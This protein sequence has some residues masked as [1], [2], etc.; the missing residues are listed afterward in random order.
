MSEGELVSI[1]MPTYECGSFIGKSIKSVQA[2][3]YRNWELI[4]VDDCS[5]DC[6]AEIVTELSKDDDRITYYQNSSNSGAA[7]SRNKALGLAK[8]RWIAFLDSDDLWEPEKLERQIKF[9]KETGCAFSYHEYKEIDGRD[10]ESGVYVSGKE[11]VGKF[12]MYACCWPGCLS[13]MYDAERIGL[14][15]I[16]D[17]KKNNDTAM[18]LKVIK[19]ADCYLLKECL[20]KYRRRT[21]SITPRTVWRRICAHYPLFRRAEE[22]NP[23]AASFWVMMNVIGNAYKKFRYVTHYEVLEQ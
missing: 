12:D 19:K 22:M 9:M 4:I 10:K 6:T 7:V 5:K 2:Q 1:I 13:V 20:G 16:N 14:I 3:T 11:H 23:V 17:I 8:G 18:W 15:Q 21:N